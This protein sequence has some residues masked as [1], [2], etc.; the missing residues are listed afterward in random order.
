MRGLLAICFVIFAG[1]TSQGDETPLVRGPLADLLLRVDPRYDGL[2]NQTC[3]KFQ[4][5]ECVEWNVAEYKLSDPE[6]NSILVKLRFICKINGERFG[7]CDNGFCQMSYRI[8][9]KFFRK[10]ERIYYVVKRYD[11]VK[12]KRFLVEA[13]TYCMSQAT[14][15]SLGE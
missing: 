8:K 2:V 5:S 14:M 15:E 10:D 3:G 6:M 12:D 7:I 4:G 1:C 13:G 11:M 9:K